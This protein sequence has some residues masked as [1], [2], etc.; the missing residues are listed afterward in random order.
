MEIRRGVVRAFDAG[1]YKATVQLED[2]P[3]F[4]AGVPVSRGLAAAAI[5]AGR[6]CCV[7]FFDVSHPEDGMVLGVY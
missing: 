3:S 1:T 7:L 4:L 6:T 2:S 5:T